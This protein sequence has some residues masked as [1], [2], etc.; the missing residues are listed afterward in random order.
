MKNLPLRA[1]TLLLLTCGAAAQYSGEAPTNVVPP[2]PSG[3]TPARIGVHEI[4]SC[5]A[6]RARDPL[7]PWSWRI[8]VTLVVRRT[9]T[10]SLEL[11]T[12]TYSPHTDTFTPDNYAGGLNTPGINTYSGAMTWDGLALLFQNERQGPLIA[13]R[14]SRTA[15]FGQPIPVVGLPFGFEFGLGHDGIRDV[16]YFPLLPPGTINAGDLERTLPPRITNV[17]EVAKSSSP[18]PTHLLVPTSIQDPATGRT[19]LLTYVE[20]T[21]GDVRVQADP[22]RPGTSWRLLAAGND[23]YGNGCNL[24]GGQ[25]IFPRGGATP[26]PPIEL[27]VAALGS[28]SVPRSGGNV[29]I[30]A[31]APPQPPL[32][33]PLLAMLAVGRLGTGGIGFPFLSGNLGLE[34]GTLVTLPPIPFDNAPGSATWN[35][36]V[37][38]LAPGTVDIQAFV[39]NPTTLQVHATNTAKVIVP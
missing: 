14:A 21:T 20:S 23:W 6:T 5:S 1:L 39:A 36:T 30:T 4:V 33:S 16:V 8:E 29:S 22:R 18:P 12:G 35:F 17:R 27:N 25:W 31:L 32:A 7:G 15:P 10:S 2:R 11:L 26:L 3:I 9:P 24:G 34:P 37:P 38:P 13:L 28:V 19:T